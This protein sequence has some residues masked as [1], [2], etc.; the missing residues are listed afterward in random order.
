MATSP[1][2]LHL[3]GER[4]A[5][6]AIRRGDDYGL[7]IT[8]VDDAGVAVSF[9]G[10]TFLAQIRPGP[11]STT[12]VET[13]T[14]TVSGAGNNIVTITLTAAETSVLEAG[15]HVWDL[16]GTAGGV[17]TTWLAGRAY[18]DNDVSR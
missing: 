17:V 16:Q 10:V 7:P 4:D 1:G 15:K 3:T 12:V 9:A 5:A 8:F 14:V 13:F 6:P 2:A 11:T 18:I